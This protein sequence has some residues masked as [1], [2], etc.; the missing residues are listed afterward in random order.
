M[1]GKESS[2]S[3]ISSN[4]N[5]FLS[6]SGVTGL[7]GIS[8]S[9]EHSSDV[10]PLGVTC[11]GSRNET[12]AA[13]CR[14][15]GLVSAGTDKLVSAGVSLTPDGLVRCGVS[16]TPDGLVRRGVSL[17]ADVGRLSPVGTSSS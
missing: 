16:L 4:T 13:V 14:L 12:T 7:T 6:S 17:G 5:L 11:A 15:A 2:K 10:F 9:G 8:T 1:S 3:R